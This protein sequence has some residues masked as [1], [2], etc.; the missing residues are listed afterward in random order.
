M[1]NMLKSR[2]LNAALIVS[3]VALAPIAASAQDMADP[4]ASNFIGLLVIWLLPIGGAGAVFTMFALDKQ[5]Q[6]SRSR[7]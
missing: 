3:A 7:R 6:Q 4:T 2:L 5:A 1:M